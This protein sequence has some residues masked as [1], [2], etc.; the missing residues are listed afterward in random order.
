MPSFFV[1]ADQIETNLREMRAEAML[2]LPSLGLEPRHLE[3]ALAQDRM[4]EAVAICVREA[5]R[6]MNE[7]RPAQYMG[8][9]FGNVVASF[10]A[11]ALANSAQPQ[12]VLEAFCRALDR[13]LAAAGGEEVKGT[14]VTAREIPIYPVGRA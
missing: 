8:H 7:E 5:V 4:F 11:F 10:M 3:C 13:G 9:A 2:K 14:M 12:A 1:D 6:M